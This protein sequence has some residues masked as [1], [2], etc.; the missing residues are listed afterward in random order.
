[1]GNNT[2]NVRYPEWIEKAVEDFTKKS[3]FP[4]KSKAFI[5]LLTGQLN[6][7]GYYE[8]NYT[9]N[10]VDKPLHNRTDPPFGVIGPIIKE[11]AQEID[12]KKA[13]EG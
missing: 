12:Q 3:R 2:R 9:E 8:E 5:W 10:V 11:K 4:S 1:M 7:Y 6:R 13:K